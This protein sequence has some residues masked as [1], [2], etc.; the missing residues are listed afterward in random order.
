MGSESILE[1]RS[2]SKV[3]GGGE[4]VKAVNDITFSIG[5]GDSLAIM[6]PS[7]SGKSTILNLAA[8]L[9][10][11]T[12][13]SIL[14]R[15]N[16]ISNLS[17]RELTG[18]RRTEI[19]MIFQT[20]NLLPTLTALENVS[21]PLRLQGISQKESERRSDELLEIVGLTER[22]SH[23]PDEMSGG[24][25]QRVAIARA[26]VANPVI[27]LADEPTGNLDT[28]SGIKVL[29][30]IKHLNDEYGTTVVLVTHDRSAASYCA[31]VMTIVDGRLGSSAD[32]APDRQ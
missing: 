31:S 4:G 27:L 8:G 6:G 14:V 17:D 2:V 3:F 13:G 22:R 10:T 20:F 26:I 7:G 5:R 18:L 32:T 19:G 16:D 9:D 11:P 28:A 25:R 12:S 15:G 29:E 23:L 1:F 24:E 30:T 21:L